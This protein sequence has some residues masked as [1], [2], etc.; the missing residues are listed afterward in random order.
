MLLNSE[1]PSVDKSAWY[2]SDSSIARGDVTGFIRT[3]WGDTFV[4][5]PCVV[6]RGDS[7][8]TQCGW[9]VVC[10]F[11]LLYRDQ[12]NAEEN[13]D[14]TGPRCAAATAETSI[15]LAPPYFMRFIYKDVAVSYWTRSMLNESITTVAEYGSKRSGLLSLT[16]TGR[17]VQ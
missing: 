8:L 6:C 2:E 14:E 5:G 4:D 13:L 11:D 3:F 16:K 10:M 1:K 9:A 15:T 12:R 7:D 17:K